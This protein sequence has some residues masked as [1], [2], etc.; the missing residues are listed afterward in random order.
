[1]PAS[2]ENP[3]SQPHRSD[4]L[5]VLVNNSPEQQQ[6]ANNFYARFLETRSAYWRAQQTN[7]A[8]LKKKTH[9]A[10]AQILREAGDISHRDPVVATATK[11]IEGARQDLEQQAS[12]PNDSEVISS[13]VE[14]P[15]SASL[16]ESTTSTNPLESN[17]IQSESNL[18]RQEWATIAFD[19]ESL[20][21]G[22]NPFIFQEKTFTSLKS[23]PDSNHLVES[24]QLTRLNLQE[25]SVRLSGFK[26]YLQENNLIPADD[27]PKAVQ[28]L[29][30]QQSRANEALTALSRVEQTMTQ[31]W[32]E[33]ESLRNQQERVSNELSNLQNSQP[34]S[35][36]NDSIRN[37]EIQQLEKVKADIIS[38][39]KHKHDELVDF[40]E[41]KIKSIF[42]PKLESTAGASTENSPALPAQS[43]T[44]FSLESSSQLPRSNETGFAL[45]PSEPDAIKLNDVVIGAV[46]QA[47]I[48]ALAK[49]Q[50]RES[51]E[52]TE[53]TKGVKGFFKRL[54]NGFTHNIREARRTAQA[55]VAMQEAGSLYDTGDRQQRN[56]EHWWQ[57]WRKKESVQ[58]ANRQQAIEA[59]TTDLNAIAER[60]LAT[61]EQNITEAGEARLK[62]EG[63]SRTLVVDFL[64][65][66]ISEDQKDASKSAFDEKKVDLISKLAEKYPEVI[67]QQNIIAENLWRTIEQARLAISHAEGLANVDY[68]NFDVYIARAKAGVRTEADL[69]RLDKLTGKIM[70]MRSIGWIDQVALSTAIATFYTLTTG[71]GQSAAR[72]L[73]R[74]LGFLGGGAAV[75]GAI[76]GFRENYRAKTDREWH[77]REM[78]QGREINENDQKRRELNEY[79]YRSEKAVPIASGLEAFTK[80]LDQEQLSETETQLFIDQLVDLE[81]RL[82]LSN[83]QKIDLISFGNVKQVETERT[84]LEIARA[85]AKVALRRRELLPDQDTLTSAIQARK[86]ILAGDTAKVDRSFNKYKNK[87]VRR[88][89]GK[90]VG[91]SLVTAVAGQEINAAFDENTNNLIETL[92]GKQAENT[93]LLGGLAERIRGP[94][95]SNSVETIIATQ[96]ATELSSPYQEVEVPQGAELI[97]NGENNYIFRFNDQEINLQLENGELTPASL[98]ALR[99]EG[100]QIDTQNLGLIDTG[101]TLTN[102]ESK[103]VNDIKWLGNGTVKPDGNEL[104]GYLGGTDGNIATFEYKPS[105]LSHDGA[106]FAIDPLEHV[107]NSDSP[108]LLIARDRAGRSLSIP[109]KLEGDRLIVEADLNT[110]LGRALFNPDG[111][112]AATYTHV[113]LQE[114]SGDIISL[115]TAVNSQGVDLPDSILVAGMPEERFGFKHII[116]AFQETVPSSPD[117]SQIV[118]PGPGIAPPLG[119]DVM[120]KT[121]EPGAGFKPPS[122]PEQG[123]SPSEEETPP[124]E[125]TENNVDQEPDSTQEPPANPTTEVSP[126][127]ADQ[128]PAERRRLKIKSGLATALAQLRANST[129]RSEQTPTQPRP[130]LPESPVSTEAEATHSSV[131]TNPNPEAINS[132]VREK[133]KP[134][135]LTDVELEGFDLNQLDQEINNRLI[136]AREKTRALSQ[137]FISAETNVR[138]IEEI[139]LFNDLLNAQEEVFRLTKRKLNL[140][141]ESQVISLAD[142]ERL[143]AQTELMEMQAQLPLRTFSD[144]P[145]FIDGDSNIT[146]KPDG[147]FNADQARRIFRGLEITLL[148]DFLERVVR[149][150][151]RS[152]GKNNEEILELTN[153]ERGPEPVQT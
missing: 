89:V 146:R 105:G 92:Q 47:S 63:E 81:A 73:G 66:F 10:Y 114:A 103:I 129:S 151:L 5:A 41:I 42:N 83:T 31:K 12:K 30:L 24:L 115:A 148:N 26:Q 116:N 122:S 152:Q 3:T 35:E 46:D 28:F 8:E 4:K 106:G 132:L 88:A 124:A 43:E 150:T 126:S 144:N 143:D 53:P 25:S 14:S 127:Q 119:Y 15:V 55:E 54:W 36:V 29:E 48:H 113:G 52:T 131:E 101:E 33:I 19:A 21:N 136:L 18:P 76:A 134:S 86:E 34:T 13:L 137:L 111:S 153:L 20:R 67:E 77:A 141:A 79:V 90:A 118:P 39:I 125:T 135:L 56:K 93:T 11:V 87:R 69:N 38:Q 64:K 80:K 6:E 70:G 147:Q 123:N 59:S 112:L 94:I 96:T 44:G 138:Q 109:F 78:A 37:Q 102:F 128:P 149:E 139:N 7:D 117:F 57:F 71:A 140:L 16:V 120:Q 145:F 75:S 32:G 65:L 60:L 104:R 51:L 22:N 121:A 1:M 49:D 62:L 9:A 61:E 82:S 23:N 95:S 2:S 72:G 40:Y 50:A 97:P 17:P 74:S 130:A 108:L 110:E 45:N 133:L 91:F 98:T 85:Q 107:G 100:F 27:L 142:K 58:G 68:D 99:Q 84:R